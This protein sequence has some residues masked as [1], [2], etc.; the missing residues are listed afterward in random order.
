MRFKITVAYDG[1]NYQGFQKQV[2]GLGI[3][4]V[5]ERALKK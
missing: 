2:N 1:A 3:Q 4:T 5:L